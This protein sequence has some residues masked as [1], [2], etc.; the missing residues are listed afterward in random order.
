MKYRKKPVVIEAFRFKTWTGIVHYAPRWFIKEDATEADGVEYTAHGADRMFN[1]GE[2]IEDAAY[3][4]VACVIKTL[5]GDM[6]AH[7]GDWII[8]GVDGEI[9]PCKH[10]IFLKTYEEVSE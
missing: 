4:G 7:P 6:W 1:K 8:K 3:P 5:E 2:W 9:Y 10:D